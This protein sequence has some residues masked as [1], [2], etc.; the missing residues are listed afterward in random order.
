[1]LE[2]PEVN[3]LPS[4]KKKRPGKTPGKVFHFD[5]LLM[6]LPLGVV[7]VYYYGVGAPNFKCEIGKRAK[8]SWTFKLPKPYASAQKSA[9]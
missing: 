2:K 6:L 3:A 4:P 9:A 7:A 5:A 8:G 1:M